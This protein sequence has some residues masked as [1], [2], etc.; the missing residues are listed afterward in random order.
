MDKK[1][2]KEKDQWLVVQGTLQDSQGIRD[3]IAGLNWQE[4]LCSKT[5]DV[6]QNL[7]KRVAGAL[8]TIL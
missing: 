4:G 6:V 7:M 1:D 3:S 8:D 2:K 5:V